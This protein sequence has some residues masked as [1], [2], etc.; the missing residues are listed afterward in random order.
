MKKVRKITKDFVLK[1]KA[2]ILQALNEPE[3]EGTVG[4]KRL[5]VIQHARKECSYKANTP[6]DIIW[7]SVET[8]YYEI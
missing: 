1:Y 6:N 5:E 2:Q 7:S 3:R 8:V 4:V